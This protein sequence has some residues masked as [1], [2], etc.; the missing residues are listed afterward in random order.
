ML[1]LTSVSGESP[2]RA[3]VWARLWALLLGWLWPSPP[4]SSPSSSVTLDDDAEAP[5]EVSP[6]VARTLDRLKPIVDGII[7]GEIKGFVMFAEQEGGITYMWQHPEGADNE[8]MA[9][10][11]KDYGHRLHLKVAAGQGTAPPNNR[12]DSTQ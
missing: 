1:S 8:M 5:V 12:S 6:Q 11:L 4:A 3:P 9:M 2:F 7:S 10:A